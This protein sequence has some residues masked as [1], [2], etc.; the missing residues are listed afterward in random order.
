MLRL[1]HAARP[2]LTRHG[3]YVG[4]PEESSKFRPR[5][6]PPPAPSGP[7][8]AGGG[9]VSPTPHPLVGQPAFREVTVTAAALLVF[10][11]F[12]QRF[13]GA[14]SPP[15]LTGDSI[16]YALLGTLLFHTI[17]GCCRATFVVE[18]SLTVSHFPAAF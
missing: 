1:A 12:F 14:F 2:S 18:T 4:S 7:R 3:D 17:W 5:P 10:P 13:S 9:P 15:F 8:H 6:M 16:V 11:V